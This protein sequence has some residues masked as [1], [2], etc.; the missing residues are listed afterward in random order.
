MGRFSF[1]IVFFAGI[2]CAI[3]LALMSSFFGL[4]T[5][6][7]WKSKFKRKA[8]AAIPD[9]DQIRVSEDIHLEVALRT[10]SDINVADISRNSGNYQKIKSDMSNIRGFGC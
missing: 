4:Q 2:A 10:R 8:F 1:F 9:D 7:I 5:E 3:L 6:N